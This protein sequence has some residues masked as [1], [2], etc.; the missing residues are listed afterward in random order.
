MKLFWRST[1]R[2]GR[3]WLAALTVVR[4]T[5]P[6]AAGPASSDSVS[7]RLAHSTGLGEMRS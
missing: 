5:R 6:L 2:G 4:I 7:M 3:R 1:S